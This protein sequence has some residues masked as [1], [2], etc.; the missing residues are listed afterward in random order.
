MINGKDVFVC[1]VCSGEECRDPWTE[2]GAPHALLQQQHS[3]H[4]GQ[5][6]QKVSR[7]THTCLCQSPLPPSF[8]LFIPDHSL[9]T[10][11]VW[12]PFP[13]RVTCIS[14]AYFWVFPLLLLLLF[15]LHWLFSWAVDDVLTKL[16]TCLCY[17]FRLPF[18]KGHFPKLAECAHFHYE[19]VDFGTIQVKIS[20]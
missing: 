11:S 8:P 9:F 5:E 19:N 6:C 16:S 14:W 2:D 10:G 15:A 13:A 12:P 7:L 20:P 3:Q 17:V 4:E 18:T 1:F